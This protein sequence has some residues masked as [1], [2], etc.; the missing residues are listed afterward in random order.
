MALVNIW[1]ERNFQV[2]GSTYAYDCIILVY[3][4]ILILFQLF[5]EI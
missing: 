5:L 2:F 1:R 3:N 4:Y